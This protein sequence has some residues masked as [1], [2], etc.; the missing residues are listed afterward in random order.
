M[1]AF[2]R[3]SILWIFLL[4]LK[5]YYKPDAFLTGICCD[6][7]LLKLTFSAYFW[8]CVIF[9]LA[10]TV[11]RW[12]KIIIIMC[13]LNI[14]VLCVYQRVQMCLSQQCVDVASLGGPSCSSDCGPNGVSI[15]FSV[16]LPTSKLNKG[17][18]GKGRT[19]V[20]APLCRH[21]PLQRRS[22]T[23]RAPSSVAHTCLMPSQP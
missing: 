3:Y 13:S 12:I 23:W 15:L 7:I 18:K 16:F 9:N 8:F 6:Y 11:V 10:T 22:G 20:I 5:T 19:L 21:G 4:L 2:L 14:C 17:K 1:S